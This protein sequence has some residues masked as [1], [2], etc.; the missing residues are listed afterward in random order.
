MQGTLYSGGLRA[1]DTARVARGAGALRAGTMRKPDLLEMREKLAS[2]KR[3]I[4]WSAWSSVRSA[5]VA[6]TVLSS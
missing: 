2:Q 3:S 4:A 6:V 1:C 5:A